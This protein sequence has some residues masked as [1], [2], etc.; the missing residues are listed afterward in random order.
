MKTDKSSFYEDARKVFDHNPG[1]EKLIVTSDGNFFLPRALSMA[2]NHA[3]RNAV[4]LFEITLKEVGGE[5]EQVDG[6]SKENADQVP[7]ETAA[8]EANEPATPGAPE[9]NDITNHLSQEKVSG[10]GGNKGNKA[11]KD[12]SDKTK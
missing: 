6:E 5:Q 10:S 2:K 8:A 1:V 12:K 4:E 11:N 3:Q 7:A 9:A